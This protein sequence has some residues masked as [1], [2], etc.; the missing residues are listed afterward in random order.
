MSLAQVLLTYN[1]YALNN[2]TANYTDQNQPIFPLSKDDITKELNLKTNKIE[3]TK[4]ENTYEDEIPSEEDCEPLLYSSQTPEEITPN[5]QQNS[6]EGTTSTQLFDGLEIALNTAEQDNK[7]NEEDKDNEVDKSNEDKNRNDRYQ[8]DHQEREYQE[9]TA[10][11]KTNMDMAS[12]I[13]AVQKLS[14][15]GDVRKTIT[16]LDFAGQSIYYAFH[17]IYLSRATFSILV[18]DMS[19]E[20]EDVC[21]PPNVSDEDFCCSRFE[22]W[23]YKGNKI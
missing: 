6:D 3:I 17:Q 8:E 5:S 7:N 18:V 9:D 21:K 14:R 23:T 10:K 15:E 22:S 19:K 12:I 2:F 16:I 1:V 13:D 4:P 11:A 20:F